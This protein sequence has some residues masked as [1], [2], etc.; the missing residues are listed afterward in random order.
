MVKCII[1]ALVIAGL[2][3]WTDKKFNLSIDF[4]KLAII[5]SGI[6]VIISIFTLIYNM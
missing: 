4:S 1:A 2:V 6:S 3:I 5:F